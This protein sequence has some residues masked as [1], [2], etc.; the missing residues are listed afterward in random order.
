MRSRLLGGVL[1]CLV[2]C[3]WLPASADDAPVRKD[4]NAATVKDLSRVKG[5]GKK[6][7]DKILRKREALGGFTSI[8]QV[9]EIKGIG[10]ATFDKLVCAF[11]V[12]AE[13]ALPCK[14]A[15]GPAA[16]GKVNV[17]TASIKE[18]T[19]LPGIGKKKAEKIV[20]HRREKGWFKSPY[21]L[22]NINGFGKKTVESLL[23][24]LEVRVDINVCRAAAFEAL[25]FANGDKIIEYRRTNRFT[26]VEDL[27]KVP[28]I[29]TAVLESVKEILIVNAPAAGDG[30]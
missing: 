25:G 20:A 30:K 24:H 9:R 27:G 14:G 23:P 12:P 2:L 11:Q 13:G 21:E 7:A 15:A 16:G 3:A 26:S 19:K 1:L 6:T 10:K 8:Y 28:G 4:I 5:I 18:L 22:Q 29:D 17:N